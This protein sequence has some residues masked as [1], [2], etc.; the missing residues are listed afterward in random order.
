MY[1]HKT[2]KEQ[3]GRRRLDDEAIGWH[4][5]CPVVRPEGFSHVCVRDGR[6]LVRI[7]IENIR[8]ATPEMMMSH[9]HVVEALEDLEK[10][11]ETGNRSLLE[12]SVDSEG[13]EDAPPPEDLGAAP[14]EGLAPSP[15][16][17]EPGTDYEDRHVLLS[18]DP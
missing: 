13:D 8:L 3:G 1:R 16:A 4:G 10:E 9:R 17:D 11:L 12:V 15:V 5:P 7:A 6:D 2:P 18:F 14:A